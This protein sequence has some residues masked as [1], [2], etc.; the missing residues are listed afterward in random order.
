MQFKDRPI[1]TRI[2]TYLFYTSFTLIITYMSITIHVAFYPCTFKVTNKLRHDTCY[3]FAFCVFRLTF[4]AWF[5]A[6][7][8]FWITHFMG[9][10]HKILLPISINTR[11]HINLMR[12]SF[13]T[14]CFTMR[15]LNIWR[16]VGRY[17]SG[18][19]TNIAL[20]TDLNNNRIRHILTN[21]DIARQT[22]WFF[23]IKL[24]IRPIPLLRFIASRNNSRDTQYKQCCISF[25]FYPTQY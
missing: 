21:D 5:N 19:Q 12:C 17:A 4:N 9:A 11:F 23:T 10:I 16:I 3:N 24:T 7:C 13:N 6:H 1:R 22:K 2:I 25:H 14:N 8:V 18:I 20:T 15:T